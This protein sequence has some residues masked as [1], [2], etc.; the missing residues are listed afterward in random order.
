MA[1]KS[2]RKVEMLSVRSSR[3]TK[4]SS[5]VA[6]KCVESENSACELNSSHPFNP[7]DDRNKYELH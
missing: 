3:K 6:E 7:L 5:T 1:S 4:I 2:V